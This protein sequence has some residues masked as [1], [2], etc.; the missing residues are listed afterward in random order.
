ME[1]GSIVEFLNNKSILVI[2]ATGFLA[3]SNVP[4]QKKFISS[5]LTNL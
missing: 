3:K 2:G 4:S 5:R 1:L